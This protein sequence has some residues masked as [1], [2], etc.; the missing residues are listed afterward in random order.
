MKTKFV[1]VE[2]ILKNKKISRFS[3]SLLIAK[4]LKLK[5]V[6]IEENLIT[7]PAVGTA[8]LVDK[9]TKNIKF[10]NILDLCCGTGALTKISILNGAKFSLCVDKSINAAKVNLNKLKNVKFL[11]KD[12]FKLKVN[13]FFDLTI[14]DP[15]RY[16]IEKVVEKFDFENLNTDILIFW[17]GSTEENE[18]H[19]YV[20]S[21]IEKY[22]K[23]I[24]SFSVYGEEFFICA[25]T[26]TGTKKLDKFFKLW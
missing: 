14:L 5:Y 20:R 3:P 4:E 16:L 11:Q 8:I 9:L 23:K 2:K 19:N 15:P 22:F 24:Y 6:V 17:H 1:P 12:I 10:N 25:K 18:W 21:V 26:D 7:G 13:D